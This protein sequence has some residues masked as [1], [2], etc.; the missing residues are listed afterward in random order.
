MQLSDWS[1]A[2]NSAVSGVRVDVKKP[3]EVFFLNAISNKEELITKL[4]DMFSMNATF[5]LVSGKISGVS[6]AIKILK[7]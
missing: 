7:Y 1:A 4:D 2:R 3:A 6:R 5:G